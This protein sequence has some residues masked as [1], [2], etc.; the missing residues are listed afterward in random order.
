MRRGRIFIFLALL[1]ILLVVAV[2]ALLRMMAPPPAAESPT[3]EALVTPTAQTLTVDVLRTKQRIARGVEFTMENIEALVDVY[4]LPADLKLPEMIT[5]PKELLGR[6]ARMDLEAQMLITTGMIGDKPSY[7]GSDWALYIPK[8]MV[9][10]SIPINRLSS[11]SYAPRPGDHV[12]VIA[13][14]LFVD[15]DAVY[16]TMLP[17]ESALLIAPGPQGEPGK[18]PTS[19]TL[20]ISGGGDASALGRTEFDTVLEQNYY[21][22]P[23]EQQR[24]RLVVSNIIQNVMVLRVGNF[25]REDE[26]AAKPTATPAPLTA[27]QTPVPTQPPAVPAQGGGTA[28]QPTATPTPPP[29]PDVIT[30]VVS[31]QDAVTLNYLVN[32]GAMLSLALRSFDDKLSGAVQLSPVTLQFL[33]DQY[34]I[35]APVK[36]PYGLQPRLDVLAPPALPNDV[37]ATPVP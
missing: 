21:A 13:S 37:V 32:S 34:G 16:Q 3:Q 4:P 14:L 30:L 26:E 6:R 27:D 8:G 33:M 10:V 22:V 17:N 15:L 29:P 36:L 35:P 24:G 11:V 12:N 1:L 20:L 5:D 9:A 31:P 18:S 23:S 28:G 25:P 2:W 19:L 7:D